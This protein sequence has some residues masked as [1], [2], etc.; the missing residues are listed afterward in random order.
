MKHSLEKH[1]L[2]EPAFR[3]FVGAM[4]KG[5]VF[6]RLGFLI[7]GA[8]CAARGQIAKGLLLLA[9]QASYI[10][11]MFSF[12]VVYLSDFATLGT[13]E[14]TTVWDE[15]VQINRVVPGDNSMMILLFSLLTIF[16][17]LI[18]LYVYFTS[19]RVGY[20][21]LKRHRAGAAMPTFI[22][23]LKSLWNDKYHFVLLTLPTLGLLAFTVLPIIFM[24][25]M[26]FTN[27]DRNHQ[28]P[29][30]LFTWVGFE[31][32][33]EI[34][35]SHPLKSRTFY[36]VLGWTLTWAVTATATCYIG[37]VALAILIN[38]KRVQLKNMWR[39]FFVITIA[40]PQ[41]ASLL[42]IRQLLND[43][44]TLNI[45]LQNLGMITEPIKFLST[46]ARITVLVVNFWIG[47]PYTMLITTGILMNIPEDLFESARIDGA[48]PITI[49][50]RITL[51]YLF[52]V[53]AP[54]LI[55]QFVGNINNFN[56]I[57]LLTN[58]EPRTLDYFQAGKTDLLITWL[59]R[60][61]VDEQ[62]FNMAASIGIMIFIIVSVFSLITFNI[63]A[64]G[65][66][67]EEFQ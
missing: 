20:Q 62:N 14:Q 8:G 32:F 6:T 30:N 28:P 52:F 59:Y 56:V 23:D 29:G 61:T 34:F 17:S 16:I 51:P 48:G 13:V 44:G 64:S 42:F 25:A 19:V 53:T 7:M 40:V 58:G 57:F 18:F 66:K 15:A 60:Q 37:G 65:K 31:N 39:T 5:D 54:F 9:A 50:R 36:R 38:N 46:H 49:F 26:A 41:F 67:E 21:A 11:F 47:V 10:Y 63:V 27:L 22:D 33:K 4:T 2:K 43:N 45:V 3:E 1:G 12:G 35:F 55:T 24:V